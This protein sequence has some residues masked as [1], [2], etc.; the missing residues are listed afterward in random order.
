MPERFGGEPR[1]LS[2]LLARTA[3]RLGALSLATTPAPAHAKT[4]LGGRPTSMVPLAGFSRLA[5]LWECVI[6][7][8]RAFVEYGVTK[9]CTMVGVIKDR[10][11]LD[12][13]DV[14]KDCTMVYSCLLVL[15]LFPLSASPRFVDRVPHSSVNNDKLQIMHYN[16]KPNLLRK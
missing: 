1:A 5:R 13:F 4:G 9:D 12:K 10:G 8:N 6:K 11:A 7:D 14:T 16:S 3:A 15:R 2:V